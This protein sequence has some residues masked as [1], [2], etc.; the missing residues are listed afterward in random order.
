MKYSYK[1]TYANGA[2][3]FT[4]QDYLF[5]DE[6]MLNACKKS[7]YKEFNK[8]KSAQFH[9]HVPNGYHICGCGNLAKG[10]KDEL[11]DECKEIYGHTYEGEL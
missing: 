5:T 3:I 9:K 7:K 10:R 4:T 2:S 8:V 6:E 1:L 11:C